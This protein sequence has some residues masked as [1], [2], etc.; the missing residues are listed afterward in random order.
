[1]NR[2]IILQIS[3]KSIQK[4]DYTKIGLIKSDYTL[5]RTVMNSIEDIKLNI[6]NKKLFLII[7]DEEIHIK[8]LNVPKVESNDLGLIIE[9]RLKYL[10]GKKSEEIF[11]TYIICKENEK[12]LDVLVFCVNC[13]KLSGLTILNSNYRICKITLI[14]L[15]FFNYY[16]RF[17]VDKDYILIFKYSN[18]IYLIAAIGE[19][20]IGNRIIEENY[21]S[22]IENDISYMFHKISNHKGSANKVY[23]VNFHS[24]EI[25]N[26]VS[27]A[28][29]YELVD[30]G[31]ISD[32]KILE[33]FIINR[34]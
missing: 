31:C 9:N 13:E 12:E 18:N 29:K 27:S 28:Q 26:Y 19:K 30:L 6:K 16:K 33:Y 14:Q 11:Y 4:V 7:E 20:I 24:D 15:C 23:Y 34:R 10:Y 22:S 21:I 32:D 25:L 8:Y 3:N 17:I 5:N 2:D 1:M